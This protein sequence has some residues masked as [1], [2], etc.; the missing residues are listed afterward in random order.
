MLLWLR[1]VQTPDSRACRRRRRPAA[2]AMAAR[3]APPR[4]HWRL[5]RRAPWLSIPAAWPRP[6]RCAHFS[7]TTGWSSATLKPC[8]TTQSAV[9]IVKRVCSAV[10]LSQL[11]GCALFRAV[12]VALWIRPRFPSLQEPAAATATAPAARHPRTPRPDVPAPRAGSRV[13]VLRLHVARFSILASFAPLA[14]KV[15]CG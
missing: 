6:Q 12:S 9:R 4:S 3:G 11:H 5:T 8:C 1:M 15:V 7:T 13:R 14:P 2:A 10:H